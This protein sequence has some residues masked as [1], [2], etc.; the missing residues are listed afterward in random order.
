M[1]LLSKRRR[2]K[3]TNRTP[4][5]KRPKA[6]R[7]A[8]R[9]RLTNDLKHGPHRNFYTYVVMDHGVSWL[10]A[11]FPGTDKLVIWNAIFQTA[12][13][14]MVEEASNVA[15][16]EA[17]AMLTDEEKELTRLRVERVPNDHGTYNVA[18]FH[19]PMEKFGGLSKQTWVR[20]RAKDLRPEVFETVEIYTK[21][22][23][24]YGLKVVIDVEL[25]TEDIVAEWVDRFYKELEPKVVRGGVLW[26]A[27]TPCKNVAGQV[28]DA[29]LIR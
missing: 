26:K 6:Y 2:R 24:G 16:R 4:W 17:M 11:E 14:A 22:A 7:R 3:R 8:R 1:N 29:N 20:L 21:W 23:Y 5:D 9:F 13:D 12:S 15:H 28:K 25:L 19:N 18:F 27:D 10:D